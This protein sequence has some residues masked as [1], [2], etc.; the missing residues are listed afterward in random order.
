MGTS[1]C[2]WVCVITVA[3]VVMVPTE[4]KIQ[5]GREISYQGKI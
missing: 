5:N 4:G 3:T 1:L 2:F